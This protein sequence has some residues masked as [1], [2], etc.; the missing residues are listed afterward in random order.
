MTTAEAMAV[1]VL[2]GDLT[3]ARAL[4]DLL[5]E[6]VDRPAVLPVRV[7][8][9]PAARVKA[10]VYVKPFVG[11]DEHAAVIEAVTRWLSDGRY[12]TLSL[13]CVERIELYELPEANG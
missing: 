7:V 2:K 3:A 11:R 9:V 1:A 6:T 10:V 8:D 5:V 12:R 4:A 13:D